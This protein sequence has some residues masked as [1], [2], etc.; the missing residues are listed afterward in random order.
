MT[1]TLAANFRAAR[2]LALP[3][4]IAVRGL[5]AGQ[6][7]LVIAVNAENDNAAILPERAAV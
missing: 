1:Q 6:N 3:G 4:H 7:H 2:R 5:H